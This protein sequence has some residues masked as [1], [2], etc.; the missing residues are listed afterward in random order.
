M[1]VFIPV[2]YFSLILI[3][4]EFANTNQHFLNVIFSMASFILLPVI[5]GA[6]L[7]SGSGVFQS[8]FSGY[9][10]LI[11]TINSSFSNLRNA[12]E[13]QPLRSLSDSAPSSRPGFD[14][15]FINRAYSPGSQIRNSLNFDS[16]L[17]RV[18]SA[19]VDSVGMDNLSKV[20]LKS[21]IEPMNKSV[22]V[23]NTSH[24]SSSA[25]NFADS[26]NNLKRFP[27]EVFKP[28]GLHLDKI[29]KLE[30][31]KSLGKI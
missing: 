11:D 8:F 16:F 17:D 24:M 1:I 14:N 30:K 10:V 22:F 26:V 13:T 19:T 31:L 28:F 21:R 23:D 6:L 3:Q 25:W 9:E 15:S 27:K 7:S 12:M 5:S 2:I 18:R 4:A 29:I 20:D